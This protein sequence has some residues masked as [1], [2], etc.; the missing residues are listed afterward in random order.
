MKQV[1]GRKQKEEREERKRGKKRK[2]KE[3]RGEKEREEEKE[4]CWDLEEE[5]KN[6]GVCGC[7][8]QIAGQ[9]WSGC[10]LLLIEVLP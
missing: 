10:C 8:V 6:G 4:N 5:R 3:R 7:A 9:G 1:C 2:Q